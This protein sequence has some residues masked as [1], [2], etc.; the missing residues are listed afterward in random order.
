MSLLPKIWTPFHMLIILC[1]QCVVRR[2]KDDIQPLVHRIMFLVLQIQNSHR[3]ANCSWTL[4][5]SLKSR[6]IY[7]TSFKAQKLDT[8]F[9]HAVQI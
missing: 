3:S 2:L 9:F 7:L 5:S 4:Y 8:F 1:L 6:L